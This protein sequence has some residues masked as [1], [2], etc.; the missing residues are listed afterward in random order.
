MGVSA[1]GGL[2]Q[3][4]FIFMFYGPMLLSFLFYGGLCAGGRGLPAALNIVMTKNSSDKY[5]R[6]EN[7]SSPLRFYIKILVC[8]FDE[9]FFTQLNFSH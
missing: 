6:P 1:E 9:S 3:G 4:E 2:I 7:N 8:L 5:C